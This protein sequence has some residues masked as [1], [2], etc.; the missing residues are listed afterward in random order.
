MH[1]VTTTIDLN[2]MYYKCKQ[3]EVMVIIRLITMNLRISSFSINWITDFI[4]YKKP[5][6]FDI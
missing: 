4:A 1:T 5:T 3:L 2:R 6:H